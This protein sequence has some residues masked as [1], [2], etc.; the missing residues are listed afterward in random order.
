M[1]PRDCPDH[2]SI[3]W[4]AR[5]PVAAN[6]LMWVCL[7]GGLLMMTRLPQE[8]FPT[9]ELDLIHIDVVYPGAS[10]EEIETGLVL[11]IE[12]AVSGLEGVEEINATA[13]EGQAL[14][15]VTVAS[16]SNVARLAQ[17]IEKN[18]DRIRSFPDDAE[19]PRV[20]IQQRKRTVLSLVLYGDAAETVL[21]ELAEQLRDR[22]LQHPGI[23]LV[24]L[25]GIR[26]R[27]ISIEVSQDALRRYRLT[28]EDIA[29]RLARANVELPAGR[30]KTPGGE[31]LLRTRERQLD[32][33][34][35]ARVPLLTAPQGGEVLLGEVATLRDGYADIDRYARYNG[36]RAVM[37]Q[38]FST[39]DQQPIAVSRAA[40]A[41]LAEAAASLPPGIALEIRRD[42]SDDFAQR[43]DLLL[44][45]GVMGLALVLLGLALF[46][47]LRLAFWVMMGIPV[48][49]L[50][51]FLLLPWLGVT[52]NMV[53]LF[54]FIIALGIVVDDA[55]VIG[56]NIYHYRQEGWPPLAA[57]IVGAQ[58]MA[59]PVAF[60]ILSNIA[61]FVPLYFIPGEIGKIWLAIPLV[62]ISVFL[63]SWIESVWVL[64]NHLAALA[65]TPSHGVL[66]WLHRHQQAFSQAFRLWVARRYGALL[67]AVLTYRY[68]ALCGAVA[69]LIVSLSYVFSGRMG[70]SV[71]PKVDADFAKVTLTLPYGTPVTTT[72]RLVEQLTAAAWRVARETPRGDELLKGVFVEFGTDDS[73]LGSGGHLAVLRAYLAPPSLREAIMSTERFAQRWRFA[74][75]ALPGAQSVLFE[76][77]AGGPGAGAALTIELTHRDI[78]VLKQASA[79]LAEALRAYPQVSDVQSGF[80]S[81]KTQ[82]DVTL[83]PA[84]RALGLTPQRVARQLRAAFYGVEVTRWQRARDE[85]KLMV[86]LP[87]DERHSPQHLEDLLLWTPQGTAIPLREAVR[88]RPGVAYTEIN[89]RDGRRSVLVKAGVTPRSQA[90]RIQNDLE[91]GELPRLIGRY[92]GLQYSFQG[93]QADIAKSLGSLKIGFAF[94]VL[95]I[96]VM[97]AIPFQSYGL[98]C[99]VLASIP[100]GIIG[101][102]FGHALMGFEL[103]ILSVLGIVALSGIVVNDALVLI[104]HA[105]TLQRQAGRSKTAWQVIREAGIQR[106]RPIILTT[107]TTF[108]GLMPMLLETSRQ[109]K[110]LIPMAISLG[111]GIVFATVITLLL[112]PALYL[113]VD[114]WRR[115]WHG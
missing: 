65:P 42:T 89:R 109:A 85:V 46:L 17:D 113:I 4:M 36:R 81:G 74:A 80:N 79:H 40:R 24:E 49:F 30:L 105:T 72:E 101:A 64:P 106:F 69:L 86:R 91:A 66:A 103:S 82:L 21:H 53:S 111:F 52:I 43:I 7:L 110:F 60:S 15:A 96:Y 57:A 31:I 70:M 50:G 8:V 25:S 2:G 99:I 18:L 27:E 19:K 73:L 9:F 61:A 56:E 28:L 23:Q 45:N 5:H 87:A 16:G 29:E 22:L 58:E 13:I 84:G 6:L 35:L 39:Q 95:A 88:I 14:L 92:P 78:A 104:H 62:V 115:R 59:T 10:P 67:D 26:P 47:E 3:A 32:A 112:I 33:H 114:D 97:L 107:L 38:V 48:A 71:F 11:A 83:L 93:R 75:G 68:L 77:D 55:I 20:T 98:P 54:A 41:V 1:T 76:S 51:S 108:C 37:L 94:A 102:I 34:A 44:K 90:L 12:E 63:W 100:F